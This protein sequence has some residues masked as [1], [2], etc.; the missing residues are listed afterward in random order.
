MPNV[1]D[2][3]YNYGRQYRYVKPRSTD[4][5][6]FRL[7]S[8]EEGIAG[9]PGGGGGTGTPQDIDGVLPIVANTTTVPTLRTTIS[10]NIQAL[11][12]RV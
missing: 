7:A 2:L 1:G 10:M 4:P 6:T 11:P 8:P 3:E 12:S 9:G 5:G